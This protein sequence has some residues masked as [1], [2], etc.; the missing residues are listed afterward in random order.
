MYKFKIEL[1][2]DYSIAEKSFPKIPFNFIY[3]PMTYNVFI[4]LKSLIKIKL[5]KYNPKNIN[6]K[7]IIEEKYKHKKDAEIEYNNIQNFL[8]GSMQEFKKKE[9]VNKV[10]S[11]RTISQLLKKYKNKL[12]DKFTADG[13]VLNFLAK[14][15][16]YINYEL[17]KIKK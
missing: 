9:E 17:I 6:G 16:I 4:A 11:N 3:K 2:Q 14:C 15:S 7:I 13:E 1:W 10:L 5:R 12:L 8:M